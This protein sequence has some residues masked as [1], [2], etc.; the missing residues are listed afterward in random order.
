MA[1]VLHRLRPHGE[2]NVR[3]V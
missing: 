1:I 2:I 3:I